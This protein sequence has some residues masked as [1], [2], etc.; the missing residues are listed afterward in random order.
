MR[1]WARTALAALGMATAASGAVTAGAQEAAGRG[2]LFGAPTAR[3]SLRAGYSGASAGS[4]LF[5]FVT[6]ELTISKGDFS[7]FSFGGDLAFTVRPRW[8]IVLTVDADGME[9]ASE[10]REWEDNSGN[11][12]EQ[13]TAFSRQTYMMSARYYLQPNGRS[14]GRFA[15][16]P[17]KY[18]PWVIAGVGRT[19]YSFSQNGDFIDYENGNSV[20]PDSF[21]SSQWGTTAQV[22]VGVDWSLNHRFA[23][24]MQGR[25]LM[26]NAKLDGYDYTG[27]EPI[28]LSGLGMTAGLTIRF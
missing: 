12:I 7:S 25:Y 28:D 4:D 22:G 14:L 1:L 5:S 17:A 27:F 2:F 13:R 16:V 24:T 26:G 10:Y 21:R 18:V 3:L 9:K 20:F 15:W 6:D 11:P 19:S 8:D 23:M